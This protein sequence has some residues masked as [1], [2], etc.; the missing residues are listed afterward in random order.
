MS[1]RLQNQGASRP[2]LPTALLTRAR[3]FARRSKAD[4]PAAEEEKKD[5]APAQEEE[6]DE[7]VVGQ[8]ALIVD[9][10]SQMA[11]SDD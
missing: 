6:V 1:T 8:S 10:E 9:Y 2:H 4:E 11:Q 7:D 5:D 3:S